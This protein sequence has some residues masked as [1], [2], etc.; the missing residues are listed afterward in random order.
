MWTDSMDYKMD[1]INKIYD[2]KWLIESCHST[3]SLFIKKYKTLTTNGKIVT[4]H[5]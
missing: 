5:E 4:F 2:E 1:T 3:S